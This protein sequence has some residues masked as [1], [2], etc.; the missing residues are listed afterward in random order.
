MPVV[1]EYL[2]NIATAGVFCRLHWPRYILPVFPKFARESSAYARIATGF[3]DVICFRSC[4]LDRTVHFVLPFGKIVQ[5]DVGLICLTTTWANVR[6]K[7]WIGAPAPVVRSRPLLVH[8][9]LKF[10][11][12]HGH[13]IYLFVIIVYVIPILVALS[14]TPS[15]ANLIFPMASTI[16]VSSGA[17]AEFDGFVSGCLFLEVKGSNQNRTLPVNYV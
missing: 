5:Q 2:K 16:S 14:L 1:R 13:S 8:E 11:F 17:L 15:E 7:I 12:M 3:R 4:R 9:D 10:C 6:S